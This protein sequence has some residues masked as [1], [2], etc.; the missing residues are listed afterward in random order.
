MFLPMTDV[1][2]TPPL[3]T[4]EWQFSFV[5]V[6]KHQIARIEEWSGVAQIPAPVAPTVRHRKQRAAK[7]PKKVARTGAKSPNPPAAKSEPENPGD[8]QGSQTGIK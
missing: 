6:N 7:Q 8:S 2:I 5:A 1:I 3:L 4:G